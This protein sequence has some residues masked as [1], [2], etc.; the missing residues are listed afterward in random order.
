MKMMKGFSASLAI[1]AV[2]VIGAATA[3]SSG[4]SAPG[5]SKVSGS[6]AQ[7]GYLFLRWQEGLAVMIWHDFTGES[8]GHS[9]GSTAGR[10]YIDRGSVQAAD[11]RSLAWEVRTRDGRTGEVEIGGLRYDLATGGLFLVTS[12]GGTMTVR[13]LPRDL[14]HVP[15]DQDGILAF[16][17]TDPDLAAFLDEIPPAAS[18]TATPT[19]PMTATTTPAATPRPPAPTTTPLPPTRSPVPASTV[20]R[21]L[22]VPG[23][24]EA[25][26]EGYLPADGRALYVMGVE[27]GQFVEMNASAG[28]TGQGHV[29]PSLAPMVSWSSLW[30]RLMCAPLC[31]ARRTTVSSLYPLSARLTT[32]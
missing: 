4:A 25:T 19:E 5:A 7:G 30:V 22:F 16:A 10:F 28:S 17:G 32:G 13:Q 6:V 20:E 8:T 18:P 11:G 24:T 14:S 31:P 27:A 21:I 9:A 3:C 26:I 29:L 12:H 15:L 23:A 1:L 2:V